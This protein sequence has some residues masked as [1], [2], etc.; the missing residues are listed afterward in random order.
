MIDPLHTHFFSI[1]EFMKFIFKKITRLVTFGQL[2]ESC[3]RPGQR[4]G[5]RSSKR[6][7]YFG[8]C[9]SFS[10]IFT[11]KFLTFSEKGFGDRPDKGLKLR[12]HVILFLCFGF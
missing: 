1:K 11:K 3:C 10:T 7:F 4:G 5:T 8:I 9:Q 12:V 6:K 2:L